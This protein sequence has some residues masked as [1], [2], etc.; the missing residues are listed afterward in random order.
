MSNKIINRTFLPLLFLGLFSSK[1]NGQ[2]S[3]II[4]GSPLYNYLDRMEIKTGC[5]RNDVFLDA[6]PTTYIQAFKFVNEADSLTSHEERYWKEID[7]PYDLY[8]LHSNKIL[9]KN[10]YVHP[11]YLFHE[12]GEHSELNVNPILGLTSG[13]E[14]DSSNINYRNSRGFV[15][16]GTLDDKFEFYTQFTEHQCHYPA[17]VSLLVDSLGAVPGEGYTKKFK[18]GGSYDFF[19][20]KAYLSMKL[21]EHVQLVL[22]NDKNFIGNGYRSLILSDFAKEYP[23][24]KIKGQYGSLNYQAI[25]AKF[26]D[27]QQRQL[28]PYPSKYGS[29]HY[30][31]IDLT[32]RFN[33][34]MYEAIM[35]HDNRGVG[36]TFDFNYY[37]PI[38]FLRYSEHQ[39][40]SPDN[41]LIAFNADYILKKHFR[42]YG[43]VLL[44]EFKKD[45]LVHRTKD[46]K[47]KQ[48]GQIGL[49]Y[50]D[51]AGIN[52]L[53]FQ[54]EF[55]II[56]PYVYSHD[57][58]GN[59]YVNFSQPL[60][61]PLGANL[62]ELN[63]ILEYT[64]KNRLNFNLIYTYS[65]QGRDSGLLNFGG[66][67]LRSTK[68]H[69]SKSK[70]H[71]LLDGD[72]TTITFMHFVISYQLKPNLFLQLEA[73][74]RTMINDHV[75]KN[76]Y[77]IGSGLKLNFNTPDYNF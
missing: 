67:I 41:S 11:Y 59:N 19:G 17:Y 16:S 12:K 32:K 25:Y 10:I 53:D 61:H 50:V 15:I 22:A 33:L 66:N 64:F 27:F 75:N 60:A 13:I 37:N 35:F 30:I 42:L 73:I 58:S 55:N 45:A 65:L 49:K 63:S 2:G 34:G 7:E 9:I 14:K 77:Y 48:S 29:I 28:K 76:E 23:Q 26:T 47:N 36:R 72:K 74:N 18:T 44:D 8:D 54:T 20:G 57:T 38:I 51:V 4:H 1:I 5:I 70:P 52:N 46:Y 62:K 24:F 21:S 6:N 69:V 68:D 3:Q 40:G 71:P 39:L 56:R 43:Q 31:S